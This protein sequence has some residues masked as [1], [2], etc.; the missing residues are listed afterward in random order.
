MSGIIECSGKLWN[1]Y[2]Q[3]SQQWKKHIGRKWIDYSS[4]EE[5]LFG[6]PQGSILGPLLFNIFT[7]D[8]F[9]NINNVKFTTYADDNTP[10]VKGDGKMQVLEFLK[11]HQKNF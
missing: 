1:Q 3:I 9:S 2:F 11:K 7:N 10:D 8:L 6:V 5:I 4:W